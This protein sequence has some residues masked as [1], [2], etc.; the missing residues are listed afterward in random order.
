MI[1]QR[2]KSKEDITRDFKAVKHLRRAFLC[3]ASASSM[4]S[5]SESTSVEERMKDFEFTVKCLGKVNA[6]YPQT[7]TL[8][9]TA[10]L[11]QKGCAHLREKDN[12]RFCVT[13]NAIILQEKENRREFAL[14]Q[15]SFCASYKKIPKVVAFNYLISKTGPKRMECHAFLCRSFEEAQDIVRAVKVAFEYTVDHKRT[16]SSSEKSVIGDRNN[17][18]VLGAK[19]TSIPHKITVMFDNL[20]NCMTL[21]K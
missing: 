7:R 1:T 16:E 2:G 10:R 21:G 15:I 19:K 17:N 13:R 18:I 5:V 9:N 14:N 8:E 12:S 20:T 4:D 11:Y 6:I 3:E